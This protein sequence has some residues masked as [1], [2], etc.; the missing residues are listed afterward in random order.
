[1]L[2]A[3]TATSTSHAGAEGY[4]RSE[5]IE[6]VDPLEPLPA[7]SLPTAQRGMADQRP[8]KRDQFGLSL[9]RVRRPGAEGY[10]RSEAIETGMAGYAAGGSSRTGAEGYGRSEAIET[11]GSSASSSRR[12]P[13]QRGMADQR[14]LK[15]F[16]AA[17]LHGD[18]AQR[19]MADQRPLKRAGADR[20]T[21]ALR[22]QAQRGMA[23]Q[24]PLKPISRSDAQ[25]HRYIARRRGVWPIRGH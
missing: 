13:A 12:S 14:P 21:T 9:R 16:S 1:M 3:V 7:S 24:R 19:G 23:D 6:T 10:G 4:G 18:A 22:R 11:D 17:E 2:V 20:L 8:L 25:V 5:A 15:R